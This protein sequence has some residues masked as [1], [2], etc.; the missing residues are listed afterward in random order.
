MHPTTVLLLLAAAASGAPE[1]KLAPPAAKVNL[2]FNRLYNYGEV[3]DALK[4][5]AAAWPELCSLA[6]IG[7]SVQGRDLWMMTIQ[8]KKTGPEARKA[9]FYID[10]NIHGNEVQGAEVALY[11]IKFLMENYGRLEKV[12]RLVDERVFYVLPMVNPDGRAWWFDHPNTSSSS[13][14]GLLPVDNDRDGVADED[15]PEDIDGDGELLMMRKRDPQGRF[16][17]SPDDP[18]LMV[19]AKPGEKG[20][21]TMLGLEGIDNDNDGRVNEDGP[22]GYDMNRNWPVDWQPEWLQGGAGAYPLSLPETRAIGEFVLAHPNIA[23]VQAYHNAGGMILRGPGAEAQGEYPGADLAV[24]DHI[25]QTGEKMLPFYR[26]LVIWKDLYTVHG[27]FV[28]WTYEGLGIFSFTN[29]LWSSRQAFNSPQDRTPADDLLFNDHVLLGEGHVAWHP[30]QHPTYGEIELGGWRKMTGRVPPPFM[31]EELCHRNAAF[32]L[33]HAEQ[34]PV[35]RLGAVDVERLEAETWRVTATAENPRLIPTRS[36]MA[37]RRKEG[38]PDLFTI[39]GNGL[40]VLSGGRVTD[41]WFRRVDPVER[42]PGRLRI[43]D[44]LRGQGTLMVEWIV[45]GKGEVKVAYDAE[46]GGLAEKTVPLPQ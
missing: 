33:Y 8:N 36:A 20:E 9:A 42:D 19:P 41:R 35:V 23:G 16:K 27:G 37:A 24:Y 39:S 12:T 21:W 3:A 1:G 18:R 7:K 2:A 13:R 5:L 38:R 22:G 6:S 32:T 45:R 30:F 31:L 15:G 17:T 28:N 29:E 14:S 44:G 43:E 46:K 4:A 25:G 10:G 26:Y 11:T 40:S 34:M